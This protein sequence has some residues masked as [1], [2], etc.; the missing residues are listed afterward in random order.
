VKGL[1]KISNIF[2]FQRHLVNFPQFCAPGPQILCRV[3][4]S[5]QNSAR[6]ESILE[7]AYEVHV[8]PRFGRDGQKYIRL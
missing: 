2:A 1:T 7:N 3:A 5:A 6:A 8:G 4:N